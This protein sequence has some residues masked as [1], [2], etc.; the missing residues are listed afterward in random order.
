MVQPGIWEHYKGG[1][2]EVVLNALLEN[3]ERP[4]VVYRALYS[5]D[6]SEYW[7]RTEQDFLAEVEVNGQSMP[8][9]KLVEA[10]DQDL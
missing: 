3:D 9:F 7:I 6:K 8:R 10:H 2:Y 1:R 4:A 5:N